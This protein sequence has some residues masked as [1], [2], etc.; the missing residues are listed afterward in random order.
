MFVV[1]AVILLDRIDE[2]RVVCDSVRMFQP[3]IAAVPN[4]LS[5]VA[6]NSRQLSRA[7][8]ATFGAQ[9]FQLSL[10]GTVPAVPQMR[11]DR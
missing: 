8:R 3:T 6:P 10:N 5:Q 1:T 9:C 11:D 7:S 4:H 2:R